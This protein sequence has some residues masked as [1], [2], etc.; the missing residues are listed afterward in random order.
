MYLC[1]ARLLLADPAAG[2]QRIAAAERHLDEARRMACDDDTVLPVMVAWLG[3][4]VALRRE[5]PAHAS[6]L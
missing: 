1:L 5:I 2:E 6:D 4:E 3:A